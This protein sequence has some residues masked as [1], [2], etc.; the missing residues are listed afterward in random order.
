MNIAQI[1]ANLQKIINP[2]SKESFIYDLMSSYNLPKA[3]I[4]RLQKGNL[5]LS[6]VKGEIDWK[7]KLF[8]KEVSSEEVYEI[9]AA[10]ISN[11]S[12]T[13]H[14]PRF[15]II[16]DYQVLLAYDTKT[17]D[18]LNIP[19]E[20]TAKHF[21][22]FLPWAGM[23][24]TQHQN[25][26]PADVKAAERMAKLYDEIEKD[27]PT[28][29]TEEIHNL[30]VF[31]SRLLFCF[32]AEDTGIFLPKG[33]FTNAIASHTQEDGSHLNTYLDKLFKVL[34]TEIRQKD[35]PVHYNIFPYVNG[36]LF[37]NSINIPSFTR[38]SRQAIIDSGKEDWSAINPDIFGSMI[39][40]VISPEH[41][42]SWG[43]HYTSVPN[44]MKVIRPLFLDELYEEFE[45]AKQ[46]PQKLKKLLGRIAK[47][48][49][50]DPACGSGNFLIIAYKE[51]RLLELKI[52]TELKGSF[53]GTTGFEEKQTALFSKTQLSLATTTASFQIPLFSCIELQNF[54]GIELDDFAH[55]IA[56][57][58]LWLAQHQMNIKFKE[59]VGHLI[60][61]LP[62]KAGGNIIQGNS[63]RI[64]WEDVF[65]LL[66]S[67]ELYILGNPPYL[68]YSMQSAAQKK[69]L[70]FV[71][72]GVKG[73][74]NLDYI[75]CWF[76]KAAKFIKNKNS[77]F[78]FVSTNS[79]CQGEQI[80]ILWPHIFKNYLEIG[81]AHTS[82]KW[83]NNAKSKAAVICIIVGV[84]NSNNSEKYLFSEKYTHQVSNINPYLVK[85]KT[86]FIERRNRPLSNVQPIIRG[87]GFSDNGNL[88]LTSLERNDI[89]SKYSGASSLIKKVVGSYELI[90]KQERW[91]YWIT[92][93]NYEQALNIPEIER[94]IRLVKEFRLKSEKK[95]TKQSAQ[96]PFKPSEDRFNPQNSIVI[97]RVSSER[98]KY[99]PIDFV[100]GNTVIIDS[101]QAIY[102]PETWVFAVVTSYMHMVWVKAVAGRLKSDY[103]YSSAL[104]YNNFPFPFITDKQKQQLDSHVMEIMQEREH[105]PEKT[106][107]QL[108]DPIKIPAGLKEAHYRLDLEIEYCYRSKPF[109]TDEERLEY[110][111]KLYEEMIAA[112]KAKGTLF[113]TEVKSQKKKK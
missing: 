20:N 58:S 42:G 92:V 7:K 51:L 31:L 8:F 96:I 99:I 78:A 71:F 106:L 34:N 35:L 33:L 74:K 28:N 79:I 83:D 94:R 46:D 23:E 93:D 26:N 11:G 77:K 57:L 5:N 75:A 101:A 38:K 21:D 49:I 41:R 60:P 36:G 10:A 29:T 84:R 17:K 47:I 9:F 22:F 90:N 30:N 100:S 63:T 25:E 68:G 27:N 43:M 111:F 88:N 104:C 50:F 67:D 12:T 113:T 91:C 103:R 56:I 14:D 82:F 89:L 53:S 73:Y 59:I 55:E 85:G 45:K 95:T 80:A 4:T 98:R 19:I 1:E 86:N 61:S 109:E 105:Y 107:S 54:Y 39:Q 16:T 24:K 44:I 18:T 81:F 64:N 3:S 52:L 62:L 69:D 2:L 15:V 40:A 48:K 32:F 13:K 72:K 6:K 70:A 97:P 110:L 65:F 66:P 87:T 108:Y 102:N 37:A 76:L 112:E